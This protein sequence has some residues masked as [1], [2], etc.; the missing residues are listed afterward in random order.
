MRVFSAE[1]HNFDDYKTTH[2]IDDDE[3]QK[4]LVSLSFIVRAEETK[5]KFYKN[6]G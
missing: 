4:D 6:R 3:W 1:G 5:H 2:F